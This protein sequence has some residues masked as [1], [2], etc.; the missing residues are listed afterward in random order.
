MKPVTSDMHR[1]SVVL[2]D[3]ELRR[4]ERL[5]RVMYPKKPFDRTNLRIYAAGCLVSALSREE[6]FYAPQLFRVRAHEWLNRAKLTTAQ[7]L[8]L[9]AL[10]R[11]HQFAA[12]GGAR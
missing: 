4:L 7:A 12:R 8:V 2:F 1:L 11:T 5:C 3:D 9:E 6:R 10:N